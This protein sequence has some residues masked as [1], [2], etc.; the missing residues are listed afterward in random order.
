[1][2]IWEL[3]TLNGYWRKSNTST[4]F[5]NCIQAFPLSENSTV[6][7]R[8]NCCP[9]HQCLAIQTM[10]HSDEQCREGHTGPFCS[11]CK[12]DY[13]RRSSVTCEKCKGGTNI[14]FGFLMILLLCF[15]IYIICLIVLMQCTKPHGNENRLKNIKSS[16]KMIGQLKTLISFVQIMSSLPSSMSSIS[17][18]A[19][20]KF[21]TNFLKIV[22][23]DI[24]PL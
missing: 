16:K 12:Q 9:N 21:L 11:S 7:A 1:M 2:Y 15:V 13:T 24:F 8:N 23:V 20:F 18:G 6:T 4:I 3:S 22:N 17:W 5:G 19:K 10:L 14:M